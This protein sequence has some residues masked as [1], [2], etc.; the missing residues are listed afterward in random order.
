MQSVSLQENDREST[1]RVECDAHLY[2][3]LLAIWRSACSELS[4]PCTREGDGRG[5]GHRDRGS[6][7][8]TTREWILFNLS[9]GTAALNSLNSNPP[10]LL[11]TKPPALSLGS[12]VWNICACW[13]EFL[14][15]KEAAFSE[16]DKFWSALF[17]TS[18]QGKDQQLEVDLSK[19][20]ALKSKMWKAGN[21]LSNVGLWSQ[22]KAAVS[23][24]SIFFP[25]SLRA[26]LVAIS[27]CLSVSPCF[28]QKASEASCP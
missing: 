25:W 2:T 12:Y 28:S 10:G 21:T 8:C 27:V 17:F 1:V 14:W 22:E 23:S 13:R 19:K 16:Q 26:R 11:H 9:V 4:Q 18:T 20:L 5:Q 3:Y 7:L 15:L 6:V 24:L